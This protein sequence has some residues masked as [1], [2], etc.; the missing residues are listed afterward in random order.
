[1]IPRGE[2]RVGGFSGKRLRP[3]SYSNLREPWEGSSSSHGSELG[4][5]GRGLKGSRP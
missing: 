4:L 3:K 2:R 5:G 1:M